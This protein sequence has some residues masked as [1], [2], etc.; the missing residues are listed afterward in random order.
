LASSFNL[1]QK[2]APDRLDRLLT[3]TKNHGIPLY[4]KENAMV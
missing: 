3:K 1:N 4:I 2:N